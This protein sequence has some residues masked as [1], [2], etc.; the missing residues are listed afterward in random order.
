MSM[1]L[2]RKIFEAH[3]QAI[4]D[5]RVEVRVV[6]ATEVASTACALIVDGAAAT[7]IGGH[8]ATACGIVA[9]L[10]VAT[11]ASLITEAPHDDR[12]VVAV[13][14]YHALDAVFEGRD[15]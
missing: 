10:K 11:I 13:A 14:L 3:T 4:M 7:G 5:L 9:V 12:G 2:D 15:P 1:I 8:V 6:L